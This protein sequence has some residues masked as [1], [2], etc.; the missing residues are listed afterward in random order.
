MSCLLVS[1]CRMFQ[2]VLLNNVMPRSSFRTQ[3]IGIM[4]SFV[5]VWLAFSLLLWYLV[6][7][8]RYKIIVNISQMSSCQI[9]LSL[10]YVCIT[11]S[12]C[13]FIAQLSCPFPLYVH[14]IF[15]VSRAVLQSELCVL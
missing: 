6:R 13:S 10:T 8:T 1:L 15:H 14:S 12:F 3:R 11:F 4:L 5:T 7:Y 2:L 9:I